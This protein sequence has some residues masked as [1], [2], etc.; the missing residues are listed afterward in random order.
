M[1][2]SPDPREARRNMAR[3]LPAPLVWRFDGPFEVCLA[4]L[5]DSLRRALVQVGDVARI[6][7]MV[8]LSLPALK[9]R[10]AAGD[11]I[12]PAWGAFLGRLRGRYGL[13]VPPRIA[14]LKTEGPLATLIVAYRS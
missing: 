12:Q 5:E 1:M 11:A 2:N 4:D 10:V 13:P 6:A 9:R 8:E 14:P 7:V 3:E